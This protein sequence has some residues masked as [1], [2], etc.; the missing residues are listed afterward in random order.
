MRR[1]Q[2]LVFKVF[3]AAQVDANRGVGC[4]ERV[5]AGQGVSRLLAV[6][7]VLFVFA[8]VCCW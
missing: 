3:V 2:F 8:C 4:V 1:V 6:F 7:A 5:V